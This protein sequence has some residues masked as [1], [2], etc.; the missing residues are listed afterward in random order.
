MGS[1]S[2]LILITPYLSNQSHLFHRKF[3]CASSYYTHVYPPASHGPTLIPHFIVFSLQTGESFHIKVVELEPKLSF[4]GGN[5]DEAVLLQKQHD[6]L[7]AKL[8]VIIESAIKGA[9]IILPVLLVGYF[10]P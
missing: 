5:L 2:C 8:Q 9:S 1:V 3:L 6:E 7:L 4:L 10:I